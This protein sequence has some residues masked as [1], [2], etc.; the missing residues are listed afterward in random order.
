MIYETYKLIDLI[1]K[2]RETYKEFNDNNTPP[3]VHYGA[4]WGIIIFLII[5]VVIG[6]ILFIW[7]IVA[8]LKYGNKMSNTSHT[9][10]I[11]F[12]VLTC[13]GL[14]PIGSIITL[15]IIYSSK[16]KGMKSFRLRLRHR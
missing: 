6:L 15:I 3:P 8:L 2:Q 16:N 5:W 12:L 13:L 10:A 4:I 1:Q 11:V 14:G 9:L 7:A